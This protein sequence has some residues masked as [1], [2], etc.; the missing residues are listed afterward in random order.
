MYYTHFKKKPSTSWKKK[1]YTK[2]ICIAQVGKIIMIDVD[3]HDD[4]GEV[5][6]SAVQCWPPLH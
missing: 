4:K 1:W 3:D 6:S 2:E 5:V